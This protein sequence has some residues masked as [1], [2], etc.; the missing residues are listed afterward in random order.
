MQFALIHV[1]WSDATAFCIVIA[2]P[3]IN[4]VYH[5]SIPV[6]LIQFIDTHAD[7]RDLDAKKASGKIVLFHV[8]RY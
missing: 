5:C 4:E 2:V 6:H 3:T 1:T 7:T 8:Y